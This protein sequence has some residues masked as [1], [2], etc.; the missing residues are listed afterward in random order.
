MHVRA[1]RF[2]EGHLAAMFA[3]GQIVAILRR[4]QALATRAGINQQ[5]K[6][7]Q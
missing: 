2:V 1:D 5:T 3:S 7:T 4:L 6:E